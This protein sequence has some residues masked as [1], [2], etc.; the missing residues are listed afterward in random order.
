MAYQA[1]YAVD[2]PARAEIDAL[3]GPLLL[4]FGVDWCPHCQRAQAPLAA[5]LAGHLAL[6]H[7][8]VEDGPGR[9]LGRS[10][11]VKLWPTLIL[12]RGGVELGRCV[13]P[14][15]TAEIR[16]LLDRLAAA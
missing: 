16:E 3:P 6:S 14:T 8:K 13:R 5:V 10:F 2:A 12:V 4:E 9:P 7:L 15:G 11:R 1:N